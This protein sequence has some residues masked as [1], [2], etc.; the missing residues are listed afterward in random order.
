MRI[1]I[2]QKVLVNKI[3]IVL[4]M[5]GMDYLKVIEIVLL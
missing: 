5:V 2:R 4:I 1:F 3:V